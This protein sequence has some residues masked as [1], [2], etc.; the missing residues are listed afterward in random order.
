MSNGLDT[1][2]MTEEADFYFD[3]FDKGGQKGKGIFLMAVIV[4]ENGIVCNENSIDKDSMA[5]VVVNVTKKTDV[6]ENVH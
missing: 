1:I 2:S 4:E 6:R 5:L 3:G